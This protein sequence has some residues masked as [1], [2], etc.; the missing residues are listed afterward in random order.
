M[1][2]V[3][4]TD[5][6][7]VGSTLFFQAPHSGG[8]TDLWETDGTPANTK[9]VA[10][11][12]TIG[13]MTEFQNDLYFTGNN[14]STTGVWKSDGTATGTSVVE[15]TV[16]PYQ[17][18][19][20]NES[21]YFSGFSGTTYGLWKI[22]GTTGSITV[23]ENSGVP[24]SLCASR[25][26]VFFVRSGNLWVTDGTSVTDLASPSDI[27]SMDGSI[28]S[29]TDVNGTLFFTVLPDPLYDDDPT[30][31]GGARLWKSNGTVDGTQEVDDDNYTAMNSAPMHLTNVNGELY[32]TV[33]AGD[34]TDDVDAYYGYSL[35]KTN[36][37]DDG[38][39]LVSNSIPGDSDNFVSN[40]T[41]VDGTLYFEAPDSNNGVEIWK[42]DGT[43]DGTQQIADI[44]PGADSSNPFAMT[45]IGGSLVFTGDDGVHGVEPWLYTPPAVLQ[46]AAD[47][48]GTID[49]TYNTRFGEQ[50]EL[51]VKGP[52]DSNYRLV[53]DFTADPAFGQHTFSLT[54]L[55]S[56]SHYF[57]R[58]KSVE[59]GQVQYGTA[60]A[61]TTSAS[62]SGTMAAT[63][64][65]A[66]P[67]H[68]TVV[69]TVVSG[70][71]EAQLVWDN[72]SDD[73]TGYTIRRL[74]ESQAGSTWT[75]A[76]TTAAD[77]TNFV[78]DPPTDTD[79][80]QYEVVATYS[81]GD[82]APSNVALTWLRR[83]CLP[84]P[85]IRPRERNLHL[86]L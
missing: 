62:S 4:G 72:T 24:T 45:N 23:V 80:Y 53:T 30:D 73:E 52:D 71:A 15:T 77:V 55:Q 27:L 64:P 12:S 61:Y 46:A 9:V 13:A 17:L 41:N 78:D 60:S 39:V 22:D 63:V 76:G 42:S 7:A 31:G 70:E 86:L 25:E 67:A 19:V 10:S 79:V 68:L 18:A 6:T 43:S 16:L 8:G 21:L 58:I 83:W 28:S 29:L 38:T 2:G 11:F 5:L 82:S 84:F 20:S 35:W 65:L 59:N 37:T 36:G 57:F 51:E 40:L 50:L 32:Y 47:G 74:D 49:L 48:A 69:P 66:A 75:D 34:K 44:D 14:G 81:G 54:G 1:I 56:S 26:N 3:A 33:D 85:Q